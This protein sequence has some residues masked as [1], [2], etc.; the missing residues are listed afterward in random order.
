MAWHGMGRPT[1]VQHA[2]MR[3][4]YC[5]GLGTAVAAARPVP[6]LHACRL[7]V[8]HACHLHVLQI[9]KDQPNTEATVIVIDG[10]F[11]RNNAAP[12]SCP[13]NDDGTSAAPCPDDDTY[14]FLGCNGR[15][16]SRLNCP[17]VQVGQSNPYLNIQG[18]TNGTIARDWVLFNSVFQPTISITAGR[19]ASMLQQLLFRRAH[20]RAWAAACT[21]Q[22]SG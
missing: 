15:P 9:L 16:S 4:W 14:W 10:I 13:Q 22:S 8:L 18:T 17:D 12:E 21:V 2:S 3:P 5:S 19:W 11:T 1:S 6:K 7:H 20:N